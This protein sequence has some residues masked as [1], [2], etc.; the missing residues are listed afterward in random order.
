MRVTFLLLHMT[1]LGRGKYVSHKKSRSLSGSESFNQISLFFLEAGGR[2][3]NGK[4]EGSFVNVMKAMNIFPRKMHGHI[5]MM[6]CI[7]FYVVYK[8]NFPC[9]QNFIYLELNEI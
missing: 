9:S 7:L 4:N 2:G 3:E 6:R 8:L 1:V 5:V